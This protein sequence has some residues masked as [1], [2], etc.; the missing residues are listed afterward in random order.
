M[1]VRWIAA[2]TLGLAACVAGPLP[3]PQDGGR[4]PRPEPPPAALEPV[5]LLAA[6][7]DEL[8]ILS[9]IP[10][11]GSANGRPAR[12][13][14]LGGGGLLAE[15][16]GKQ[17]VVPPRRT[18][19]E[20]MVVADVARLR[21]RQSFLNPFDVPVDALYAF[22]LPLDAA[23]TEFLMRVGG[24]KI[25]GI[26]RERSEAER[27]VEAARRGG[28]AAS[29]LTELRP[30][31]FAQRVANLPA[32]MELEV[33]IA[34]LHALPWGDGAWELAL[35]VLADARPSRELALELPADLDVTAASHALEREETGSG[36]SR[37]T[38]TARA[39]APPKEVV[40]R[41]EPRGAGLGAR[42]VA[43]ALGDEGYLRLTLVAP[44]DLGELPERPL[45]LVLVSAARGRTASEV[46][47]AVLAQVRPGDTF[48]AMD[49]AGGGR[50]LSGGLQAALRPEPEAGR[51]RVVVLLLDGGVADE[52]AVLSA[53][54]AA[55]GQARFLALGLGSAPSASLVAGMALEGRAAVAVL[56]PGED[57]AGAVSRFLG[58]VRHPVLREIEIDWNGIEVLEAFP[59]RIE[60]LLPGR[61]AVL[62]ARVDPRSLDPARGPTARGRVGDRR[63]EV[64]VELEM[65]PAD[66]PLGSLW[67]RAKIADLARGALDATDEE[68]SALADSALDVA[69]A[70]GIVCSRTAFLAIDTLS[71]SEAESGRCAPVA[72]P[73]PETMR[74]GD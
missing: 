53:V 30:N 60:E 5:D 29:L 4:S 15:V 36:T 19:V 20:G 63:V 56:R 73:L 7:V 35:P 33:T 6:G 22:P 39:G 34:Y 47:E 2:L 12:D 74:A 9:R 10:A 71:W 42:A 16:G 25:R 1:T 8:W 52:D 59:A 66:L 45:E 24:R 61:A 49:C 72:L 23:I 65:A 38:F 54:R 43:H 68:R 11:D 48:R 62:V 55:A 58:A 3:P 57:P 14:A 70:H 32:G 40:L 28:L 26:V 41:L 64:P 37:V 69:L 21:V 67:A 50:A 17:V 13:S 46:L 31:V 44:P 27:L 51:Q 18:R